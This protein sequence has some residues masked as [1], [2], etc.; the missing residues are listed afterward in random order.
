MWITQVTDKLTSLT[1]FSWS[2]PYFN[3]LKNKNDLVLNTESLRLKH[4]NAKVAEKFTQST[5]R[6]FP[7]I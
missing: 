6:D 3:I 1:K 7:L 2:Y 5:Q 4:F